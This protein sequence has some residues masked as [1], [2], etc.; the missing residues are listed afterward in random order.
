MRYSPGTFVSYLTELKHHL[1]TLRGCLSEE[2]SPVV[3]KYLQ[4]EKI[5]SD[6]LIE[7]ANDTV[8]K[9][10]ALKLFGRY[11]GA[12]RA[13][14]ELAVRVRNA[15]HQGFHDLAAMGKA[16]PALTLRPAVEEI[17]AVDPVLGPRLGLYLDR[18]IERRLALVNFKTL[19]A[20]VTALPRE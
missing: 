17:G 10:G 13:S 19:Y 3:D 18:C 16:K 1:A 20:Y 8:Q 9:K 5:L 2:N 11:L 6:V 12:D 7:I 14:E 15:I 4:Q